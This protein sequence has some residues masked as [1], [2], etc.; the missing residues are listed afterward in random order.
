VGFFENLFSGLFGRRDPFI[1]SPSSFVRQVAPAPM[2]NFEQEKKPEVSFTRFNQQFFPSDFGPLVQVQ[3][4]VG[5]FARGIFFSQA[6]IERFPRPVR[7]TFINTIF[8]EQLARNR[9]QI[10]N[11]SFA[12]RGFTRRVTGGQ[13]N[14]QRSKALRGLGFSPGQARSLVNRSNQGALGFNLSNLISFGQLQVS[15]S[16]RNRIRL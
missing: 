6:Q 3:G 14:T 8:S 2:E 11:R 12:V 1:L 10:K 15:N 7:D 13:F 16:E 9:E 5:S 4:S